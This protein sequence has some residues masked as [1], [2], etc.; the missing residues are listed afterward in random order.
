[1]VLVSLQ[2]KSLAFKDLYIF[3][4]DP[5]NFSNDGTPLHW[6]VRNNFIS[7]TDSIETGTTMQKKT[8]VF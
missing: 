7:Y 3:F 8:K 6:L 1:M 2:F 5:N 4:E